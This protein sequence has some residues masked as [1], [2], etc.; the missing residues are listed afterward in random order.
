MHSI[1]KTLGV[2]IAMAVLSVTAAAADAER[3][4]RKRQQCNRQCPAAFPGRHAVL[5]N[6]ENEFRVLGHDVCIDSLQA[7]CVVCMASPCRADYE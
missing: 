2:F 7:R 5:S 3:A 6:G 4:D 1:P